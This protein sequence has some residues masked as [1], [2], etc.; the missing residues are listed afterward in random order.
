M[1][2]L[3]L[4]ATLSLSTAFAQ[5]TAPAGSNPY[6]G[7]NI[8]RTY[9]LDDLMNRPGLIT[10]GKGDMLILDLPSD[11]TAIVTP[12]A[13]MMDIPEPLG[14]V[15]VL[16]GKVSTGK[17]QLFVQL[18]NG[19]FAPFLVTFTPG[20]NGMKRIRILDEPRIDYA[21]PIPAPTPQV[22]TMPA[23][24]APAGAAPIFTPST[25]SAKPAVTTPDRQ[26][27]QGVLAPVTALPASVPTLTRAQPTWLQLTPYLSSEQRADVLTLKVSNGGARPLVFSGRDVVVTVDGRQ[28]LVT[29][30]QEVRVQPGE[31]QMVDMVLTDRV[32]PGA[33]VNLDWLA[34]DA[35][36]NAYYRVAARSF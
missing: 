11:V 31:T 13:A 3:I 9:S 18:E 7:A 16:T 17:A 23:Y 34:F 27:I 6:L 26:Q 19:K 32:E 2:K 5:A 12:Q 1:K 36:A 15:V 4:L 24:T 25:A 10:L 22:T 33:K 20:G 8:T 29:M 35:G 28:V 21:Q 30:A 14:N